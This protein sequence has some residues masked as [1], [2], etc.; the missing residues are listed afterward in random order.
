MNRYPFFVVVVLVHGHIKSWFHSGCPTL[1]I[2]T[3]DRIPFQLR[4][5]KHGPYHHVPCKFDVPK[6]AIRDTA[7]NNHLFRVFGTAPTLLCTRNLISRAR[8][9]EAHPLASAVFIFLASH[10]CSLNGFL[11]CRNR[12]E[13]SLQ[14]GTDGRGVR[15]PHRPLQLCN[16][17][18]QMFILLSQ[19]TNFHLQQFRLAAESW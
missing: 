17:L 11:H 3:L 8:S 13:P 19:T 12:Y 16:L 15:N 7:S 4:T 18:T 10:A 1:V 6:I 2:S 5:E 14:L 9:A